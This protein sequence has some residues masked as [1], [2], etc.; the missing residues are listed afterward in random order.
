VARALEAVRATAQLAIADLV[1]Q[2][3]Y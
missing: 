3:C 1:L 2:T